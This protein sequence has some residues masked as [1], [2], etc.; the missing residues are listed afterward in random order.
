LPKEAQSWKLGRSLGLVAEIGGIDAIVFSMQP[1]QKV[2]FE[3]GVIVALY[4]VG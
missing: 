3:R 1:G 4:I 2:V